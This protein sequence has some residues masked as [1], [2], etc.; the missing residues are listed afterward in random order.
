[1]AICFLFIR[2]DEVVGITARFNLQDRGS[3]AV[4]TIPIF[5]PSN[6]PKS[7]QR[8]SSRPGLSG[9]SSTAAYIRKAKSITGGILGS[10]AVNLYPGMGDGKSKEASL[11]TRHD[12]IWISFQVLPVLLWSID[13]TT[14]P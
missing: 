10:W 11:L 2:G 13:T 4:K 7:C 1:M 14:T 9:S 8:H 12:V 6:Y 3:V 5:I